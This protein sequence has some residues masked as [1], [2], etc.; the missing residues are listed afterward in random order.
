MRVPM[1]PL[2][3]AD[4]TEAKRHATVNTIGTF[5]GC[6]GSSIGWT[7]AGANVMWANE[8]EPAAYKAYKALFPVTPVN[9]LSI[10]EVTGDMIRT[11]TGGRPI[12]VLEGSPPCSNFSMVGRGH[13]NWGKVTNADSTT[14]ALANVEDLFFEWVRLLGEVRPAVGVAENVAAMLRGY[15][16]G[17]A[18]D[19]LDKIRALGYA[20]TIWK[21]DASAY[22]TPQI[23]RRLFF[24]AWDPAKADR[25]KPPARQLP[26]VT[27]GQALAD[28]AHLPYPRQEV[29]GLGRMWATREPWDR[30]VYPEMVGYDAAKKAEGLIPGETH[31]ERFGLKII[32]P[33]KPSETLTSTGLCSPSTGG[34]RHWVGNRPL[35]IGEAELLSGLPIDYP[36]PPELSYK[37]VMARIGNIVPPPLARAVATQVLAALH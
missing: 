33:T 2:T 25:P 6:G 4:V 27:A 21:L 34:M 18:A 12:H 37:Q 9:T 30:W 10:T 13:K 35:S 8:F 11:E 36:W 20:A 22:G 17:Y 32:D 26:A 7:L 16:R 1:G 3:V 5:S 15:N 31:R 14:I 29:K 19:V 28:Y 23:R 24:V